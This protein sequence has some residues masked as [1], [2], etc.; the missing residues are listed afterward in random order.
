VKELEE[1]KDK[2][3]EKKWRQWLQRGRGKKIKKL[4]E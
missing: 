3:K 4:L 2:G 1:K